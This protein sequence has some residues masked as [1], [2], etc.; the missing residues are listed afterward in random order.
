MIDVCPFN[1]SRLPQECTLP[2]GHLGMCESKADARIRVLESEHRADRGHLLEERARRH[3]AEDRIG[4]LKATLREVL[5]EAGAYTPDGKVIARAEA[6]LAST[7]ETIC[8]HDF[9]PHFTNTPITVG[10]S[11]TKCGAQGPDVKPNQEESPC[12]HCHYQ[13]GAGHA[14][15]CNGVGAWNYG[16]C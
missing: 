2:R 5:E 15:G 8:D 7:E 13:S 10:S 1:K 4:A 11:C 16:R 12:P 6:L 14:Q 3:T 9:K